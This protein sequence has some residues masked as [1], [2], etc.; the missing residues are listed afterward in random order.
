MDP[1]KNIFTFCNLVMLHKCSVV[2]QR[3]P[4]TAVDMSTHCHRDPY[5]RVYYSYIP[6]FTR[7]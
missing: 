2:V 1:I 4:D 3:S 5:D 6:N 7:D